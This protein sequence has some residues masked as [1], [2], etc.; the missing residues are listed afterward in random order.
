MNELAKGEEAPFERVLSFPLSA[1]DPRVSPLKWSSMQITERESLSIKL[2][3]NTLA[4][5]S[6][7]PPSDCIVTLSIGVMPDTCHLAESASEA[8][9]VRSHC[10]ARA[11]KGPAE[12]S[13]WAELKPV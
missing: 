3:K 2:G 10:G 5:S 12:V 8:A 1:P 6:F 9:A 4:R 13:K 7:R 11:Q